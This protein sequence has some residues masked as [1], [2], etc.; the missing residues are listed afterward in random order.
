[1][2]DDINTPEKATSLTLKCFIDKFQKQIEKYH[3]IIV[4]SSNESTCENMDDLFQKIDNDLMCYHIGLH[5]LS[6]QLLCQQDQ[7]L[8][9]PRHYSS[10]T[11]SNFIAID[12]Q[13]D[14]TYACMLVNGEKS[15]FLL[16]DKEFNVQ[17]CNDDQTLKVIAKNVNDVIKL[18]NLI[19]EKKNSMALFMI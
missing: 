16:E 3:L 1:M 10:Y 7:T 14:G 6:M 2:R 17:K 8:S 5:T 9:L 19:Q 11:V 13:N 18:E 15:K 4:L 12:L